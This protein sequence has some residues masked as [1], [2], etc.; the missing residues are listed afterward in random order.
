MKIHPTLFVALAALVVTAC[1]N[2]GVT[3]PTTTTTTTTPAT[4]APSASSA[5]NDARDPA[6]V[7]YSPTLG[8]RIAKNPAW[9]FLSAEQN[10]ANLERVE[11]KDEE[12]QRLIAKY[13]STPL[14]LIA[15]HQEPYDDLNPSLKINART[16]GPF[17]GRSG[18]E[19]L[20][21]MSGSL[22]NAFHDFEMLQDPT[23]VEVGGQPAGYMSM[24]YSLSIPDGRTFPTTS[25][26]W[27]V[28]RGSYFLLIGAGSEQDDPSGA[29]A[30]IRAMLNSLSF[31]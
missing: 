25:E 21:M 22:K 31:E 28:P 13:S 29:R 18:S 9:H 5:N 4:A 30:D 8:L 15:R 10:R 17:A 27:V 16:A 7:F 1:S 2:G 6:D 12:L 24:N 14:V 3:Q 11:L 26:L 19:L 23:D 20:Q